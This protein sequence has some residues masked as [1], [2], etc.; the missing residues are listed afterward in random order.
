MADIQTVF[1]SINSIIDQ[2]TNSLLKI[3]QG[4]A[5]TRGQLPTQPALPV[6]AD[7]WKETVSIVA[8][9]GVIAFMVYLL[10]KESR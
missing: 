6:E 1:G 7:T 4:Q 5:M 2:T 9:V 3:K 10:W 8:L